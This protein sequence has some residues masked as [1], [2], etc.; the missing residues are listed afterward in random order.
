MD[1]SLGCFF[2]QLIGDALG[3]RY[4]F[5]KSNQVYE[6]VKNDIDD[7]FLNL[8][9]GGTYNLKPGQVT[10]DSE[11]AIGLIHSLNKNKKYVKEDVA[12]T[13]IK[14]FNSVPFDFGR[15]TRNALG[16]TNDYNGVMENSLKYNTYSQSNG[17]LMRISPL[18]IYGVNISDERLR[19]IIKYDCYMTNPNEICL[20]AAI[21]YVFTIRELIKSN[22]IDN[23]INVA[24][25]ECKTKTVKTLLDA[26]KDNYKGVYVMNK[27]IMPDENSIGYFGHAFL[28]AFY[29]L[30][31]KTDFYKAMVQTILMGGDTDTNGCICGAL[32]GASLGVNLIPEKWIKQVMTKNL[33]HSRLENYPYLNIDSY[34]DFINQ[35]SQ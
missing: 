21:V 8:L 1:Y 10:D 7:N 13:Y 12:K 4:E 27:K 31:H 35:L 29:H 6:M 24:Y 5:K 11:M 28:N 9:G 22:N 15:T 34:Y 19:K 33:A 2:G 26:S 18:G 3:S 14:W 25:N 23:A 16:F 17:F 30:I 20:D 32:I